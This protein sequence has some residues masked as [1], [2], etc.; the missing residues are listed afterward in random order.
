M[1]SYEFSA[2]NVEKAIQLGLETLKKK[3]ED[4]DIKIISEGG[5]FKKAK[6]VINV[7]EEIK[8]TR[9]AKVEQPK[10]EEKLVEVKK[11][12]AKVEKTEPEVKEVKTEKVEEVNSN[13]VENL[14]VVS[15]EENVS[16]N[17][18]L[19]KD[20]K[21]EKKNNEDKV[22][23]AALKEERYMERHYENNQTSVD[24]ITGLLNAFQIEAK[25]ELAEKKDNSSIIIQTADEGKIIGYR[26]DCLN[27]IQYL[28]NIVEQKVNPH[29]KRVVVNVGEYKEKREK[30]LRDLAIRIAGKVEAT[31]RPYKLEPM[32]AYERRIIHTEIQKYSSVETH[33]EGVEPNRRLVVT[34]VSK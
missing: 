30:V 15:G 29:A 32:N 14:E 33:S 20:V 23:E 12:E 31:G 26:G 5:L 4:V 24:F 19:E 17:K 34:R 7:E 1:K 25:V 22:N 2:K 21:V 18:N 9:F 16:N 6:I 8:L 27:A 13:Q 11:E 28:A 3:Q 10:V